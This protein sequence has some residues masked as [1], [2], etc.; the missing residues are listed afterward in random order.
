MDQDKQGKAEVMRQ[1]NFNKGAFSDN[2]ESGENPEVK[3]L[4]K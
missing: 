4:D 1:L 3:K 2:V